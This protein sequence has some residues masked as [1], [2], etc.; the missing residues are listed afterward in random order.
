MDGLPIFNA[1]LRAIGVDPLSERIQEVD[2]RRAR[3][4]IRAVDKAL[5]IQLG[6]TPL[7]EI[8]L[9]PHPPKI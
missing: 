3:D 6:E 7:A 1:A 4:A 9:S 8:T 5:G 2:V